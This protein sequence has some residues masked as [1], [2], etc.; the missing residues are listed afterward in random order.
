MMKTARLWRMITVAACLVLLTACGSSGGD[1]QVLEP[2][3]VLN[4]SNMKV[5]SETRTGFFGGRYASFK[6]TGSVTNDT[7]NPINVDNLPVLTWD[8]GEST[9]ETSQEKLLEGETCNVTWEKELTIDGSSVPE[10]SF[11]GTVEYTGLD[12]CQEEL[13]SQLQTIAS[14]YAAKDTAKEEERKAKEKEMADAAKKKE[15]D[16]AALNACEGASAVESKKVADGTDYTA[17]FKDSYG[18]DVTNDVKDGSDA[19]LSKVIK[20]EVSDGGWFSDPSVTF[21]LDYTDPTAKAERDK[22]EEEEAIRKKEDEEKQAQREQLRKD[23][24][25][26]K[27]KSVAHAYKLVK[28]SGYK[29]EFRLPGEYGIGDKITDEVKDKVYSGAR[30]RVKVTNVSLSDYSDEV[31]FT[32]ERQLAI[33]IED[34]DELKAVLQVSD[35]FDPSISAFAKKYYGKNIEFDGCFS[36]VYKEDRGT[37]VV[38]YRYTVLIEAMDYSPDR[39]I[40]PSF[41]MQELKIAQFNW[42]GEEPNS[43]VTGQNAHF[44]ARLGSYSES[45]GLYELTPLQTSLR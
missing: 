29:Y 7:D 3:K 2:P 23:I 42:A 38:I 13:N 41:H 28:D 35:N 27:G 12:E 33:T 39:S 1:M 31:T 9:A 34:N 32:V 43:I 26:C 25:A 24:K 20:V 16:E 6:V 37:S 30:K 4:F 45:N 14:E 15:D 18:E 8:N 22:K 19:G 5:E 44:V 40:G 10:L 11:S 17:F 36:D 21:T